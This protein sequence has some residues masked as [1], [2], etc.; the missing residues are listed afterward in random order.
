MSLAASTRAPDCKFMIKED[1][2]E[3]GVHSD[4]MC[5]PVFMSAQLLESY[6]SSQSNVTRTYVHDAKTLLWVLIWVVAHRSMHKDHWEVG[7]KA[8]RTIRKLSGNDTTSLWENKKGMLAGFRQL[9]LDIQKMGTE[10]SEDLAPVIGEL[11]YF[12]YV[13][14]YCTP[15]NPGSGSSPTNFNWLNQIAQPYD[16]LHKQYVAESRS[17]TFDRLFEIINYHIK[18]LQERRPSPN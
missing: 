15:P 5:T 10:S 3:R 2:G 18:W 12:F 13:Y 14:L 7:D 9:A 6:I 16:A 11:A 8:A 1:R 17:Q 4:R